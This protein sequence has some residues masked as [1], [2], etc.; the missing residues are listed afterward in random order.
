MYSPDKHHHEHDRSIDFGDERDNQTTMMMMIEVVDSGE[1]HEHEIRAPK[2][3]A[4]T[5]AQDEIQTLINLRR[6]IDFLFNATKSNRHLWEQISAKMR[7]KGF[8]RSPTMCTDKWRNLLKEFKKAKQ[9]SR[10]N[11]N[12]NA[13]MSYY[14]EIAE[15]LKERSKGTYSS[16]VD[17]Y[18]Q[19]SVKDGDINSGS[20][21]TRDSFYL[22][23]DDGSISFGQMEERRLDHEGHP[24]AIAEADTVGTDGVNPWNWREAS[25]NGGD[26]TSYEGKI[27]TVKWGDFTRKVGVDGAADAIKEAIKSAFGLRT[28]RGF[29]LEDEYQVI[30][31]L[32]RGMPLGTYT[33]HLDEGNSELR[34]NIKICSYDESNRLPVRTEEKTFYSEDEFHE[35]LNRRGWSCLRELT[36]FR[37]VDNID[38]LRPGEMYQCVMRLLT[39]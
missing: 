10:G 15:I 1:D 24:L 22:G 39:A 25:G 31:S 8:D 27:I 30:R 21:L 6:E 37:S 7:E 34:I 28:R 36:G 12:A 14:K 5:W 35:F 13:K 29:W 17:S 33:L 20:C 16:K 23:L 11:A 19:L 26:G 38:E 3:R 18:I 4:E 9:Q 2:K 32:D